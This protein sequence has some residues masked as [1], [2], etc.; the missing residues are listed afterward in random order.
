MTS[1][2]TNL[3]ALQAQNAL[4]INGRH[5]QDAMK[6]LSTGLRVSSAADDAAGMAIG[7]R[8]Q[9]RILSL[10]QA[11]R[12]SNDG[13]T[14]MQTADGAAES[15]TNMLDRMTELAVQSANGTYGTSDRTALNL[16]FTQLKEGMTNL[17]GSTSWNGMTLLN[18]SLTSP[19]NFQLG[20][21]GQSTD[22][23]QVTF[24]DLSALA[25]L[26]TAGIDTASNALTAI[27]DIT[28][29]QTSIRAA[30]TVWG[31]GI[32]RLGFAADSSANVSMNLNAS[33]SQLIDADYAKST[34]DLARAQIIQ[35][36]GSAMLSQANQQAV[37]V[38]HLLS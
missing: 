38:L 35:E 19:V 5:L 6:E 9:S 30:R 23:V 16:E 3:Q 36:A 13:I 15:L 20:I 17:I 32:N 24:N 28:T 34:A 4:V 25:A 18:G 10:N 33:R 29:S 22:A 12:N 26:T 37:M 11:A 31:A 2:N 27:T 1:I 14:M 21:T 7:N 8:M